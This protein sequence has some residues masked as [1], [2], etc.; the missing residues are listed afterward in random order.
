MWCPNPPFMVEIQQVPPGFCLFRGRYSNLQEDNSKSS[1][2]KKKNDVS[3]IGFD[4]SIF[5]LYVFCCYMGMGQNL[6]PLVNIKI[7]GKWMFIPLKMVLIG[8]D[9]YPYH[10]WRMNDWKLPNYPYFRTRPGADIVDLRNPGW[11]GCPHSCSSQ[12]VRAKCWN[13]PR[14][15]DQ[16]A[17]SARENT[18]FSNKKKEPRP[19]KLGFPTATSERTWPMTGDIA[20]SHQMDCLKIRKEPHSISSCFR[21]VIFPHFRHWIDGHFGVNLPCSHWWNTPMTRWDVEILWNITKYP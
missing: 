20:T 5:S 4:F 18:C 16:S 3:R 11:R 17:D 9:P 8:I 7:A 2:G 12:K 1:A 15:H 14:K 21:A 19:R 6:V 13:S 10:Y